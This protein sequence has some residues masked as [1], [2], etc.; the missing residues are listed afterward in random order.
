MFIKAP[1]GN[2]LS[3][4]HV[5]DGVKG[6]QERHAQYK[7]GSWRCESPWGSWSWL[8]YGWTQKVVEKTP[9]LGGFLG[10]PLWKIWVRQLGWLA[11]QYMG[12]SKMATTPPTRPTTF[13]WKKIAAFRNSLP[14]LNVSY[15]FLVIRW[16]HVLILGQCRPPASNEPNSL[17]PVAWPNL[18]LVDG[19]VFWSYWDM[20]RIWT[21]DLAIWTIRHTTVRITIISKR[22]TTR[23][24]A[25]KWRSHFCNFFGRIV[26]GTVGWSM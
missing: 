20:I 10:P 14:H 24:Q 4:L 21:M 7:D 2:P 11:T 18:V 26:Q 5:V 8:N 13:L 9:L 3:C 17:Q 16:S 1:F 6:S 15:V 23:H 25:D 19:I 22:R 12:K